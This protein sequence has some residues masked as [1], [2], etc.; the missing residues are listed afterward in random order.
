M[1]VK[2]TTVTHYNE[3]LVICSAPTARAFPS[4]HIFV[5]VDVYET[6]LGSVLGVKVLVGCTHAGEATA[7]QRHPGG[8]VLQ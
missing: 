7:V 2:C 5:V 1:V 4:T 3:A 8:Q 6:I